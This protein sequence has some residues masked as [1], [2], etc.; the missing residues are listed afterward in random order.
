MD[1]Q[2]KDIG[3]ALK[4]YRQSQ[5]KTQQQLAAITGIARN[6]IS[7][8]ERGKFQGSIATLLKYMRW[9]NLSLSYI[10]NANEY[11]QLE[12]LEALFGDD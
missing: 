7:D 6:I 2:L 12:E 5:G 8:I 10:S 9:A 4:Q 3:Q 1:T 11:P